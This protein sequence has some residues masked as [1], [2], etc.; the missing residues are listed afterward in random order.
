MDFDLKDFDVTQARVMTSNY[1]KILV[2][3]SKEF[4]KKCEKAG[5]TDVLNRLN[6][7]NSMELIR[8]RNNAFEA[9]VKLI[10]NQDRPKIKE[11]D[12]DFAT[13]WSLVWSQARQTVGNIRANSELT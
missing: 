13:R 4:L 2:V 1:G 3:C 8:Q 11:S 5:V 7:T 6:F 9:L 12:V 10:H